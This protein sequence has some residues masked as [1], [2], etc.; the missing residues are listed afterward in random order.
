MLLQRTYCFFSEKNIEMREMKKNLFKKKNLF[1]VALSFF[2]VV[3]A[4]GSKN[5]SE[6]GNMVRTPSTTTQQ[7]ELDAAEDLSLTPANIYD[8]IS[9]SVVYIDTPD[10]TGS[11]IILSNGYVLTN[12]HVVSLHSTVRIWSDNENHA[13]VPVYARDW[14]RDLALVG[15]F[16]TDLPSLSLVSKK[17]NPGDQVFLIGFPGESESQP[18][19]SITSGIVS[20]TRSNRCSGLEFLQT[21]ALIAGGQSGGALV[22]SE[23]DLIGISGLGGFTEANFALVLSAADALEGLRELEAG[24]LP[25]IGIPDG[26][27]TDQKA[28]IDI[29]KQTVMT[30]TQ[31]VQFLLTIEDPKTA[32]EATVTPVGNADLWLEI[33]TLYGEPPQTDDGLDSYDYLEESENYSESNELNYFVVDDY[34]EGPETV[35][36]QLDPG[37]Y[38]VNVGVGSDVNPFATN[39]A[40]TSGSEVHVVSSLPLI[41][42]LDTQGFTEINL[43]ASTTGIFSSTD[44]DYF[45]VNLTT[46]LDARIRVDSISDPMMSVYY[47]DVLVASNDD[48]ASG[49][50]GISSEVNFTPNETGDYVIAVTSWSPE[51]DGYTLTADLA[52]SESFC[53]NDWWPRE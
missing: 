22:D 11:G 36:T 10:G 6:S 53:G 3:S 49:L 28:V 2:V 4:C 13:S 25:L 18:I 52:S 24:T 5:T 41:P 39:P 48:T 50:Y 35:K 42:V 21:D 27:S 17:K 9:S 23:G 12:A 38:F 30:S 34:Y 46:G 47:D 44:V 26:L 14:V 7:A 15:P 8:S 45:K 32:F 1:L 29:S 37:T 16:Q 20:R 33:S 31:S 19:P 51:I 40:I 43:G